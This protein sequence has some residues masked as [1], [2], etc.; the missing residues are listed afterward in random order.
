MTGFPLCHLSGHRL[1]YF[2]KRLSMSTIAF[3]HEDVDGFRSTGSG[4]GDTRRG[5]TAQGTSSIQRD[6]DFVASALN[7]LALRRA[8]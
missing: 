2:E 1:T 8:T 7:R 3:I 6:R 5:R 4:L